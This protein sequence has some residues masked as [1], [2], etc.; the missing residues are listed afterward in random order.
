MSQNND[1]D[2]SLMSMSL[3]LALENILQRPFI[4][5]ETKEMYKS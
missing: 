2:F 4:F 3:K 5:S 1:T